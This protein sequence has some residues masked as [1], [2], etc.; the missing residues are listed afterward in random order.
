MAD[1][2]FR[3]WQAIALRQLSDTVK[4][5]IALSI[6]A[7]GFGIS[8]L[9]DPQFLL[10]GCVKY[11]FGAGLVFLFLAAGT[12]IGCTVVRLQDFRVTAQIA[13]RRGERS[14]DEMRGRTRWLGRVTWILFWS[15][16]GCFV[17]GVVVLGV[18]IILVH[19]NGLV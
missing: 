11:L 8:E 1:D 14:V 13:H 12:G 7:L 5:L 16:V 10:V 6:G 18:S 17:V 3:R 15:Q 4:L 19:R 2:S 9:R